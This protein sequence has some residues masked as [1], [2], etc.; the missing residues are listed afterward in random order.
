MRVAFHLATSR[1]CI[2]VLLAVLLYFLYGERTNE[3][4]IRAV[5]SHRSLDPSLSP[6]LF[7]TETITFYVGQTGTGG[8][9][10]KS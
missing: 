8:S 5:F 10:F 2:D 3:G 4:N 6:W 1:V 9:C 7:L